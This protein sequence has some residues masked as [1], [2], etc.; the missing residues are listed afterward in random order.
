DSEVVE[1]QALGKQNNTIDIIVSKV[2]KSISPF[3]KS[4]IEKYLRLETAYMISDVKGDKIDI[5]KILELISAEDSGEIVIFNASEQ[6]TFYYD[7]GVLVYG[8]YN[9]KKIE[10]I[11]ELFQDVFN[12]CLLEVDNFTELYEQLKGMNCKEE[13]I[14]KTFI[15]Y[16]MDLLNSA[17]SMEDAVYYVNKID[18]PNDYKAKVWIHTDN[19]IKHYSGFIEEQAEINKII[20]DDNI[21]PFYH[22]KDTSLLTDFEKRL[23]SLCDGKHTVGKILSFF[24]SNKR[25]VKS[26]LGALV[27]TNFIKFD[28]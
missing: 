8:W 18:I 10:G 5:N 22:N 28:K 27:M 4:Y 14:K 6:Y 1:S 23:L 9:G 15:S 13:I 17:L 11:F 20:F 25:F 3:I 16:I 19:L 24:G 7:N 12:V 26:I 21:I 2:E